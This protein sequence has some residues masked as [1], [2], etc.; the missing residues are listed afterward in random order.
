MLGLCY[1]L[2]NSQ[3]QG[4]TTNWHTIHK[5][6]ATAFVGVYFLELNVGYINPISSQS[7]KPVPTQK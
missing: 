1:T 5:Y 7:T 4:K 2:S 3:N 6:L